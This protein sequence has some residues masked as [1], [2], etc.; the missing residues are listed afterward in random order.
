MVYKKRFLFAVPFGKDRAR[1]DV[2]RT[3]GHFVPFFFVIKA[4]DMLATIS[5]AHKWSNNEP[6]F[7]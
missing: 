4:N 5:L 6:N 1:K 3:K 2:I 7:Y